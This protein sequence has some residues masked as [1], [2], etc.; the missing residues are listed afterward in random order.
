MK[1]DNLLGNISMKDVEEGA[2]YAPPS[3]TKSMSGGR[4]IHFN[5]V[6]N[7]GKLSE[8]KN[9]P[10]FAR[11]D[12]NGYIKYDL[13]TWNDDMTAPFKGITFDDE[14]IEM[15]YDDLNQFDF[16]RISNSVKREFAG[17]KAKAK[18]YDRI[19]QLSESRENDATWNKEVNIIDWGYGKKVDFR[20]WTEDYDKCGKGLCI[21]FEEAEKLVEILKSEI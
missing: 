5:I 13:R 1:N 11:V 3:T 20:K 10:V 9:A 15:L 2:T 19:S 18:F 21:T 12:W 7:F 4:S 16:G 17:G 6:Q 14:E 8:R